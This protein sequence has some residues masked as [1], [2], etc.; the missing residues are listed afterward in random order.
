MELDLT[1]IKKISI[2]SVA[3]LFVIEL[4]C[5]FIASR[6]IFLSILISGVLTLIFF[7][8][9]LFFYFKA[10]RNKSPNILKYILPIFVGKILFSGLA[11]FLIYRFGYVNMLGF[12]FSFLIFFTIFFNLE[13]FLIYKKVLFY[14]S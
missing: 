14:R 2:I 12:L 10:Y 5:F 8:G 3:A 1:R 7:I 9:T 13:I 11:F 6:Q 4:A